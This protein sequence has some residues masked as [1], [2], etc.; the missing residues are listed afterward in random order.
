MPIRRAE[1]QG[2]NGWTRLRQLLE[3][4]SKNTRLVPIREAADVMFHQETGLTATGH[5]R[6]NTEAFSQLCYL[7]SGGLYRNFANVFELSEKPIA[8]RQA[9]ILRAYNSLMSISFDR[10]R[11]HRYVLDAAQN[12]VV[13]VVGPKYEFVPNVRLVQESNPWLTGIVK[14]SYKL[15]S[16]KLRN[17]DLRVILVRKEQAMADRGIRYAQG[18]AMYNSETTKRAVFLPQLLFDAETNSFSMEGETRVNRLIHRKRKNFANLLSDVIRGAVTYDLLLSEWVAGIRILRRTPIKPGAS[19]AQVVG[20]VERRLTAK[21]IS[22]GTIDMVLRLISEA[23]PDDVPTRWQLYRALIMAADK[24][25]ESERVLRQLAFSILSK[26][27]TRV[28]S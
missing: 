17:R 15:L 23:G 5:F 14:P 26:A 4:E 20:I 8:V 27:N 10:V 1:F 6:V 16:A 18:M 13:G 2:P 25:G 3:Y 11:N 7:I 9:G 24:F 28:E 12:C 21:D 19:N 22:S